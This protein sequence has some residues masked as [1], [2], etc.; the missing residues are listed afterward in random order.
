MDFPQA[1]HQAHHNSNYFNTSA[2]RRQKWNQWFGV[3]IW[4]PLPMLGVPPWTVL[5]GFSINLIYQFFTH[6]QSVGTLRA[7]IEFVFNTP[8]HHRVHHGSDAIY[9]DRNFGRILILWDRLFGTFQAEQHRPT[10]GLTTPVH[11]TNLVHLQFH[12]YAAM[13]RDAGAASCLRDRLG[14]LFGP[15]GWTPAP[16]EPAHVLARSR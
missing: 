5:A 11:S 6:T 16:T 14:F 9:L 12:E 3:L 15:P 13:M 8:S 7:P 10:Y 4:L 2:A 1:A